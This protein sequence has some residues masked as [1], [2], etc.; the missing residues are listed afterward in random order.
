ML[1]YAGTH[2]AEGA[3]GF[4]VSGEETGNDG[5]VGIFMGRGDVGVSVGG[6][7]PRLFRLQPSAGATLSRRRGKYVRRF[8][9]RRSLVARL[10]DSQHGVAASRSGAL[11]RVGSVG[12]RSFR[13]RSSFEFRTQRFFPGPRAC[14]SPSATSVRQ[15]LSRFGRVDNDSSSVLFDERRRRLL[16]RRLRRRA[17]RVV[18]PFALRYVRS[19][20]TRGGENFVLPNEILYYQAF[21]SR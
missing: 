10:L 1:A 6:V 20:R 17:S 9:G 12:G 19:F 13:D 16:A 7:A 18:A 11:R 8:F 4:A 21:P 14:S 15:R 2:N 5:M 3:D